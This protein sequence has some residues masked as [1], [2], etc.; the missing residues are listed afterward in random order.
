M[1]T[2]ASV[3]PTTAVTGSPARFLDLVASE[4][5]KMRSLRSTPWAIALTVV[6]VIGSSAVAALAADGARSGSAG[7]LPYVAYP[8]AGYW[9][10]ILV[11]GCVGALTVVSEYGSGLIRTTTV[12]VPARGSVVL[13]KAAVTATLWTA[14]GTVVS[15]GSFL[16]SQA[17][18]GGQDAGVPL[19]HPGV[20]RALVASA[21]LAPV[22]ALIGL[23]L[24]VLLR[25]SAAT[26]VTSV[27]TLLM[28]PPMFSESA[29]WSAVVHHAMVSAAWKRL[30]QNWEPDPGSLGHTATVPGSWLVYVLWPL[31]AV[32]LAVLVV[33]RRDV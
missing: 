9:T 18:L 6:F 5:I 13:A 19:T 29:R 33:R 7:F 24:G 16:V 28:L 12:A 26:M 23:G 15:T 27:F 32:A 31:T 20:F 11:S 30:V 25:H 17:V 14:V 1:T 22:C 8:P 21:L 2:L 10:L 3:P 4:W